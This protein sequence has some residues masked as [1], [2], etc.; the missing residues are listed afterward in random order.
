[1]CAFRIEGWKSCR[2]YLMLEHASLVTNL[3]SPFAMLVYDRGFEKRVMGGE[4]VQLCLLLKDYTCAIFNAIS[5]Y[6]HLF[7]IY[8]YM[9]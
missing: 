7:P 5:R 3:F 8:R 6:K 1:M 9:Q 4:Q 2:V